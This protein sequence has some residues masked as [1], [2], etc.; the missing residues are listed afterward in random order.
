[1]TEDGKRK[2]TVADMIK[3]PDAWKVELWNKHAKE[4][5]EACEFHWD[6]TPSPEPK[7]KKKK[8][9]AYDTGKMKQLKT[10]SQHCNEWLK[11]GLGSE[12]MKHF[13]SVQYNVEQKIWEMQS[14]V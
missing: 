8:R 11:A 6:S 9:T 10:I 14:D 12:E 13:A 2:A 7:R 1:M 4:I 5:L 3:L